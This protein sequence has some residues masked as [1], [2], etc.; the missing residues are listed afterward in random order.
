[1]C[2]LAQRKNPSICADAHTLPFANASFSLIFSSLCLQWAINKPKTLEEIYRVLQ[3]NAHAIISV[4]GTQTLQELRQAYTC[5]HIPSPLLNF[6][7]LEEWSNLA[8]TAGLKIL[9]QHSEIITQTHESPLALMR[10]LKNIGANTPSI[11]IKGL[12]G[13]QTLRKVENAYI[14][15]QASFEVIYLV[16]QKCPL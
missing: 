2:R 1:M 16:L 4:L 9:T 3:P 5:A 7:T 10:S 15:K 8:Q 14:G 13:R 12:N 11:T 6:L